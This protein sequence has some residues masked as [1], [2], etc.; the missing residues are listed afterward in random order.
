MST[1]TVQNIQG[2]SSSSNTI[3]V[4]S[5]HKI[6]GAA[7]SIVAPGQILQVVQEQTNTVFSTT[8]TSFVDTGFAASITP[9]FSSSKIYVIAGLNL[10]NNATNGVSSTTL[11][12]DGSRVSD[13]ATYGHAYGYSNAGA[14]VHHT[15]FTYLDSPNTTSSTEYKIY[16]TCQTNGGT[17][18]LCVN[19]SSSTLTL[20]EIA[21]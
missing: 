19:N 16:I 2:S 12:R 11:Y 1:L 21:Q 6:S 18:K 5:G 3:S 20:M 7:G 15:T 4:A 17:L 14:H 8:S 13:S 9:K 10:Y